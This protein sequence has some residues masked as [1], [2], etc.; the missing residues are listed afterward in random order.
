MSNVE[1]ISEKDMS[2]ISLTIPPFKICGTQ[3]YSPLVAL[4]SGKLSLHMAKIGGLDD[5]IV[6][7]SELKLNLQFPF[8]ISR[9]YV[10]HSSSGVFTK[11]MLIDEIRRSYQHL[12]RHSNE[13]AS[14]WERSSVNGKLIDFKVSYPF[15][16]I[17]ISDV[18]YDRDA[19]S[20]H[21]SAECY[22]IIDNSIN[23][24]F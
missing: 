20:I 19:G 23:L 12:F 24:P 13:V 3:Y 11:K 22:P 15:S 17:F 14:S 1:M 10:I 21:I 18:F 5:V 7:I 4:K 6:H 9:N 2:K 8:S 16:G